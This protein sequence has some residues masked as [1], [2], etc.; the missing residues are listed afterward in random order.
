MEDKKFSKQARSIF[1]SL[2][3]DPNS[4]LFSEEQI[5]KRLLKKLKKSKYE[6]NNH[7]LKLILLADNNL[8]NEDKTP[9][10]I[11]SVEKRETDRSTLYS[12]DGPFQLVL[13]MWE[14][15]NFYTKMQKFQGMFC[16]LLT[17]IL[18]KYMFVLCIREN[19]Y[20][21]K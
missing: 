6:K 19:R 8:E 15:W 18:Q 2:K 12:F 1:S 5:D 7:L 21:R 17:Y 11:D 14:I 16:W 20:Y 13:Q 3:T 10:R 4:V 9:T